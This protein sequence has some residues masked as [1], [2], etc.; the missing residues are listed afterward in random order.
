MD[1]DEYLDK[2]VSLYANDDSIDNEDMEEYNTTENDNK[3]NIINYNQD[4]INKIQNIP[5]EEVG[6]SVRSYNCLK[7]EGINYLEQLL[8]LQYEDLLRIRNLGKKSIDECY[9]LIQFYKDNKSTRVNSKDILLEIIKEKTSNKSM[10]LIELKNYITNNDIEYDIDKIFEDLSDLRQKNLI[11]YDYT[12]VKY[13]SNN[14]ELNVDQY[15]KNIIDIIET[16]SENESL[17]LKYRFGY[18]DGEKHTLE[19]IGKIF[20]VTRERIRQIEARALRKLRHPSRIKCMKKK[21]IDLLTKYDIKAEE[22]VELF[23][24]KSSDYYV[25]ETVFG[26]G[27]NRIDL[28]EGLYS[29]DFDEEQKEKI[30]KIRNVINVYGEDIQCNQA[31]LIMKIVSMYAKDSIAIKEIVDIYNDFIKTNK[32]EKIEIANERN[33]EAFCSRQKNIVSDLGKKIRYYPYIEYDSTILKKLR[34]TMNLEKGCY[35]TLVLFNNNDELMKEID[36]RSEYELHNILKKNSTYFKKINFERSPIFCVGKID[37]KTFV[38][39]KMN[40]LSPIQIKDFLEYMYVNYGHKENTMNSYIFS[41]LGDYIQ[42]NFINYNV[43]KLSEKQIEKIKSLLNDQVYSFEELKEIFENSDLSYDDIVNK[44]NMHNLGYTIYSSYIL[45]KEYNS[46]DDYLIK[47]AQIKDFI[48]VKNLNC[49]SFYTLSKKAIKSYDIFLISDKEY[50]TIKKLNELNITKEMIYKF[51]SDVYE[52]FK[53]VQFFSI[54][55]IKQNIDTS[56]IDDYGFEDK[57]YECIVESIE[58][59]SHLRIN[60]YKI[61]SFVNNSIKIEDIIDQFIYDEGINLDDLIDNINSAYGIDIPYAK[62][63]YSNKY[64]NKYLNKIYNNSDDCYKEVYKNE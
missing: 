51:C 18:V 14:S 8:N 26:F 21:Y 29:N 19:E 52:T 63:I 3:S 17:V 49:S 46:F 33:I 35:S 32:V 39:N 59:I 10:N 43:K 31:S 60:G 2:L 48:P 1:Y 37:K 25:L 5:L 56:W 40:E 24:Q 13:N 47:E 22:Y 12:G 4:S 16:L 55:N 15:E 45:K 30:R 58:G 53:N 27:N 57:F 44:I 36:I 34:E 38:K 50:I 9:S 20:G 54:F 6:L 28:L 42:G 62:I 7:R 64:Y 11:L 41:E 23:N 61:Y